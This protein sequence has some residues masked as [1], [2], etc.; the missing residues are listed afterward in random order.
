MKHIHVMSTR[1]IST[2]HMWERERRR[3]VGSG[4]GV[5]EGEGRGHMGGGEGG[6]WG[7]GGT[8]DDPHNIAHWI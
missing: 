7:R 5:S 6:G 1:G 4:G 8:M 3:G 2:P